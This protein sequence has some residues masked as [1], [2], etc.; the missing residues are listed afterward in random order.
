[1]LFRYPPFS[2]T[3]AEGYI[4]GRGALDMKQSLM[5]TFESVE[6][7][8]SQGFKPKRTILIALGDD[9]ELGG[10]TGASNIVALLKQRKIRAWFSI[11]E[12]SGVLEG[13]I[14]GGTRP[15]AQIGLSEKGMLSLQL[16]VK[17]AGGHSSMPPQFTSVGRIS[18]AIAR[19]E[20]QPMKG[21]LHGPGGAG[22][23]AMAPALPF[24]Q[25]VALANYWL[26]S[27]LLLRQFSS[28]PTINALVRTTIAPTII[29]GGV[30]EN[31]LPSEAQAVV[32]FRLAP[33]DSINDVVSHV[34]ATIAD[35]EVHVRQ[36][37]QLHSEATAVADE[38]GPGFKLIASAIESVIPEA[39]VIPGLV[40]AGTDS[41]HYSEVSDA[42]YRFFPLRLTP[43]DVTRV[44]GTDERLSIS[45]YGEIITFY[46]TLI[47]STAK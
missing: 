27:P 20:E 42:A 18:R 4:W 29:S 26:F 32:N 11:D 21:S 33:G 8:L 38:N 34:T 15:I 37:G 3:I 16:S 44:H 24:V 45:N 19:L 28:S 13:F 9:E 25:R 6:R 30:K 10:A 40:V 47:R 43:N 36:F 5:A 23:R 35:P 2:G 31:V 41:R 39:L 7:L 1:M 14:P 17:S 22:L 46:E 12:G